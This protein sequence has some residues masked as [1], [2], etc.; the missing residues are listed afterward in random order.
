LE[1]SLSLFEVVYIRLS[2]LQLKT[3][4]SNEKKFAYTM[5]IFVKTIGFA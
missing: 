4:N 2:C 5:D 1:L 3:R